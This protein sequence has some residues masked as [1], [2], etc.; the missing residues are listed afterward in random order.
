MNA[1]SRLMDGLYLL[2][3]GI[4]AVALLIMVTVIPIGIF[5]RYVLNG[6]LSWPE[7]V[8][9]VCMIIFTFIGAPVGLRAG[10]HICVSMVTDRLSETG[11]KWAQRL[12]N[13]LL[14]VV[15][16]ILL[17][18]SYSLCEAMWVQP[19]AALPAVT[20]GEMYLPIPIGALFTLLFVIERI[21]NGD[22]S[23]RPLVTLGG[24]H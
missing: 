23:Q 7:P 1:Y 6:A 14:I 16:L 3:M 2:C 17:Q 10:T 12:C 13:L 11:Q 21:L 5:A 18:A 15:C 19:L 8:A 20:Y 22:Q 4:A 24:T 9:I